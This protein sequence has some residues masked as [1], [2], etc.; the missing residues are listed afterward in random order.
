MARWSRQCAA[1]PIV[2]RMTSST[3]GTRKRA[4]KKAR[5]SATKPVP[6]TGTD[7]RMKMY[8]SDHRVA[9]SS[10]RAAAGADR[11]DFR[12]ALEI[13][14][15]QPDFQCIEVLVHALLALGSR[16]RDEV[17]ALREQPLQH[18]L[19]RGAFLLRRHL[20]EALD[21]LHVL[22]EVLALEARM[23]QAPVAVGQ[24][25]LALDRAGE[26][27]AAERRVGHE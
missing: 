14:R 20:L 25:G 18:E 22:V 12:D 11:R 10:H 4:A 2:S 17:L 3:H 15:G 19:R 5:D 23:R 9:N 1:R 27:R 26:H 8:C 13:L 6:N 21:D 16:D 7:T 24:V